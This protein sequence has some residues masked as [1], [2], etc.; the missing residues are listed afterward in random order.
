MNIGDRVRLMTGREEGIITRI[1]QGDLIEVAIDNEFTIPLLRSDVV[2][3]TPEEVKHF[4]ARPAPA[5]ITPRPG[6]TPA[7]AQAPQPGKAAQ[8]VKGQ[9][10][11]PAPKTTAP[12]AIAGAYLVLT[13]QAEE[14]LAVQLVNNTDE[15]LLYTYGEERGTG[16]YK[17][18]K[19]GVVPA[20]AH[21]SLAFLHLKDF[22]Q[23]PAIVMQLLPHHVGPGALHTLDTAR[24]R[25]KAASFYSARGPAPLLNTEGYVYRLAEHRLSTALPL[26]AANGGAAASAPEEGAAR[27]DPTLLADRLR[28]AAAGPPVKVTPPPHEVDLHL[29][30]LPDAP[31]GEVSNSEALRLQIVVFE[32]A[33]SRALAA[34]MHEIVFI[35]GVSNGTLRK[36]IHRLLSRNRDIKFF[37]EAQK[38]KFGFGATL[39]RL[40]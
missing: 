7:S 29:D 3:V 20:R 37:E 22:E 1:L 6:S 14:L 24:V 26:P 32:D 17:G 30:K 5:P 23:W 11:K 8:P 33:L 21:E 16:L 36:E 25:F 18:V 9:P 35:H 2:V 12:S 15:T 38:E 13:H 39:V 19:Q 31:T 4:G 40:K 34:N 27:I 10:G 28:S